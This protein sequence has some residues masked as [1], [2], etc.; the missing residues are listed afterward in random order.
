MSLLKGG[1]KI[2][3]ISSWFGEMMP[4]SFRLEKKIPI[5][6]EWGTTEAYLQT[7]VWP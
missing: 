5:R 1:T 4:D 6:F 2:I 7:V 3:T